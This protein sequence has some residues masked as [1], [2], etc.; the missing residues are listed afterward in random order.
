M[1]TP[2]DAKVA[3]PVALVSAKASK[4][5][6]LVPTVKP[7]FLVL[8]PDDE[9]LNQADSSELQHKLET[10]LEQVTDGVIVDLLWADAINVNGIAAMVAGLQRATALGKWMSFQSM[11]AN[12]RPALETAWA[13]QQEVS[14]G[15]W[16]HIFSSDLEAFLDD[17]MH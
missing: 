17:F 13:Q 3:S 14:A 5:L 4:L 8:Q 11:S 1:N 12:S 2:I 7:S 10:M 6:H 9:L 16:S 15:A